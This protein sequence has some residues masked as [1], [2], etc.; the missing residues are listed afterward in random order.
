M[1]GV[2]GPDLHHIPTHPLW[3]ENIS[4]FEGNV[5]LKFPIYIFCRAFCRYGFHHPSKTICC[6]YFSIFYWNYGMWIYV[7]GIQWMLSDSAILLI[8]LWNGSVGMLWYGKTAGKNWNFSHVKSIVR[9]GPVLEKN[10]HNF[11]HETIVKNQMDPKNMVSDWNSAQKPNQ[12]PICT[13]AANAFDC[14]C[15]KTLSLQISNE[16]TLNDVPQK[17]PK[18][19]S[20]NV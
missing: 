8:F 1:Q 11:E 20:F 16:N 14:R 4:V 7:V 19:L 15:F 12:V 9:G 6:R 13:S 10:H 18:K 3:F 17:R 5:V 2:P